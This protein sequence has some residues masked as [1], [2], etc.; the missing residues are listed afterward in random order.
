MLEHA[1]KLLSVV[2]L[3][4][5]DLP[6]P[7][8]TLPRCILRPPEPEGMARHRKSPTNETNH[9]THPLTNALT[10]SLT[11]SIT[12][13]TICFRASR[14]ARKLQSANNLRERIWLRC[15][16]AG[17]KRSISALGCARNVTKL[18]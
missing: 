8:R 14:A 2:S 5:F 4:R 16:R 10:D 7:D 13:L 9:E 1:A 15:R 6:K 18:I 17:E 11:Y 3:S 12:F